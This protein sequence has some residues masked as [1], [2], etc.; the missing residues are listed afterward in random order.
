MAS[1]KEILEEE[2]A[3][4]WK[5]IQKI[6]LV[7]IITTATALPL[8]VLADIDTKRRSYELIQEEK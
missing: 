1:I 4:L 8:D 7:G 3:K 2:K 5:K 6:G